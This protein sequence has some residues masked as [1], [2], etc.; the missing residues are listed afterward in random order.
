MPRPEKKPDISFFVIGAARCG[1]TSVYSYLAQHPRVAIPTIKEPRFFTKNWKRGWDWYAGVYEHGG[2][3]EIAGDFSPGYSNMS[4]KDKPARRIA[5]FYPDAKIVYLVRNPI[6]CALSNWRMSAQND[7][8]PPFAE[9]LDSHTAVYHRSLFWKQIGHYREYFP[10]QQILVLPLEKVI[11]D[12]EANGRRITDFLGI[13]PAPHPF[14]H[15]NKSADK[16]ARPD[17]PEVDMESRKRFLELVKPGAERILD[18]AGYP[19][20][21]EMTPTYHGWDQ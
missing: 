8:A 1:T 9:C 10:D 16:S 11:E 19:G 15:K 13:D 20:L 2:P 4:K 12:P 5:K 21:W 6:D 18:Y 3:G 14:P 7:S 17:K